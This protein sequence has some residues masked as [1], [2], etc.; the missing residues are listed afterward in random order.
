ML[1]KV[2]KLLYYEIY[3]RK[4]EALRREKQIKGWRRE[5]KEN[6]IA[7]RMLDI[8]GVV[9]PAIKYKNPPG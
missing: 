3:P 7:N 8:S 2:D 9:P 4:E 1:A 5:K 6:L